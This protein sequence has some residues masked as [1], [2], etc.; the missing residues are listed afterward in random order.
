MMDLVSTT[1]SSLTITHL[2][3]AINHIL[4]KTG[5]VMKYKQYDTNIHDKYHIQLQGWPFEFEI[6][7]PCSIHYAS[8]LRRLRNTLRSGVCHWATMNKDQI[9][10][11][12]A[13][14]RDTI[15]KPQKQW[16][17]KGVL[18][19]PRKAPAESSGTVEAGKEN[20]PPTKKRKVQRPATSRLPPMLT[21]DNNIWDV[22]SKGDDEGNHSWW[23]SSIN[24]HYHSAWHSVLWAIEGSD[25]FL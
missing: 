24:Q 16:S 3:S 11:L 17:D 15:K 10:L 25:S 8:D 2:S 23:L 20:E 22:D 14:L 6:C 21:N 5:I 12:N 18:Q 7:S 13:R 9:S 4:G 19:G 1:S